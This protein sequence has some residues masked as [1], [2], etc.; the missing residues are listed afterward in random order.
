M[1]K[2]MK[3]LKV[4][5]GQLAHLGYQNLRNHPLFGMWANMRNRCTNPKH[6]DFYLYGAR[7]IKVCNRWSS[8]INFIND[9][10]ERPKG[11]SIDRINGE[12]HYEPKN[13]RWATPRQQ[14]VN[15]CG[16]RKKTST[17]FKGVYERDGKYRAG[18][19]VEGKQMWIGT[20]DTPE[21]AAYFYNEA[22][23]KYHGPNAYLNKIDWY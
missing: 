2:G 17:G 10:G 1:K 4:K 11:H 9:M 3:N 22:A 7:E 14:A 5:P 15:T 13:C 6:S 18:L 19:R 21:A 16:W 23:E 8:F 12:G 20:F